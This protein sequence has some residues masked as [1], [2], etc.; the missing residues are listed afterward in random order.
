MELIGLLNYAVFM[1]IFIGIYSLLALGLNIQWGFSGLFNAGIAGFFAVGAYTSALLTTPES[2]VHLGGYQLPVVVGWIGAMIAAGLIAWPIGKVCLR[3]RSDYLA[4]ATIGVAE[5]IRLVV[6][7][8]GWMT[9]GA[10]GVNKVPR[11]FGD[12]SYLYSQLAYLALVI[13]IVLIVYWAIERQISAPWGRMMRGIRDNEDAATAMGKDIKARR[14]E[15]FIF[16]AAVMGLGGAL[17][18]HFNRSITPEAIDPMIATFLIWIMLILGG[19]GNNRGALLGVA[20]VWIIWS[21]SEFVTDQLP[22]EYA[23][24]AKYMRV[25]IIGLLLQIVLRFRPE[26]ILP[27]PQGTADNPELKTFQKQEGAAK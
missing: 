23:I 3:F 12:L 13:G 15:A 27:E 10:R 11:P 4:I 26:G 25:F 21:A 5:I 7:S 17:F 6:K 22:T 8:E 14:L 9:G 20:V 18:A 2:S 16:G 19:S 1:A 24:K